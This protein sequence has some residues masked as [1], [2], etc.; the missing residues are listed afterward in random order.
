[1][2][3]NEK[4]ILEEVENTLRAYLQRVPFL[5]IESLERELMVGD[6]CIDIV[7]TS[8]LNHPVLSWYEGAEKLLRHCGL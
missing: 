3:V 5:E 8:G 4:N 2:K 7:A 6:I 1:M